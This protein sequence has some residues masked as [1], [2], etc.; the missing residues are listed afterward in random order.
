[1]NLFLIELHEKFFRGIEC[2]TKCDE[3]FLVSGDDTVTFVGFCACCQKTVFKVPGF[4]L[5][6]VDHIVI[7]NGQNSYDVKPGYLQKN[8]RLWIRKTK[9]RAIV[10][11]H[12]LPG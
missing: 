11:A 4:L 7:R 1:M 3:I 12:D 2:Y 5:E 8:D 9:Y 6:S 10:P